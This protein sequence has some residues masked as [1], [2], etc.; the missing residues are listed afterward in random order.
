M[1]LTAALV[2]LVSLATYLLLAGQVSKSEIAVGVVL[3]SGA[4][5]W[6]L[7]LRHCSTRRFAPTAEHLSVWLRTLLKLVPATLRTGAVLVRVAALGGSPGTVRAVPFADGELDD[8]VQRARR[9]TAILAASLA[10][11]SFVVR[12]NHGKGQAL[13]HSIIGGTPEPDRDWLV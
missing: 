3:A 12:A 9:A 4:T 1:K 8:P 7:L 5:G 13:I 2:W 10:P 6:Y 11:D